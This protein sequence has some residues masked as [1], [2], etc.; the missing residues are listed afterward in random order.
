MNYLYGVVESYLEDVAKERGFAIKSGRYKGMVNVGKLSKAS[1]IS[2]STLWYLLRR[3]EEFRNLSVVTLA[4]LCS[5]LDCQVGDLL[6]YAPVPTRRA[7]GI[8]K[9]DAFSS[10]EGYE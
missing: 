1:G 10:L 4:K 8:G 5:V 3:P 6:K 9:T 2:T 7:L